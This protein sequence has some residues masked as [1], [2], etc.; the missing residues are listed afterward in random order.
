MKKITFMLVTL[1]FVF[2]SVYVYADTYTDGKLGYGQYGDV[3]VFY[4]ENGT[5]IKTNWAMNSAENGGPILDN[6]DGV[7][8]PMRTMCACQSY[9]YKEQSSGF[10]YI[11]NGLRT[12]IIPKTEKIAYVD[13]KEN[14][15]EYSIINN[16]IYFPYSYIDM[17]FDLETDWNN[18]EHCLT[19]TERESTPI[20]EEE[21]SIRKS[22]QTL[23]V[24]KTDNGNLTVSI[25]QQTVDFDDAQPFIDE[26]DRTQ[27]PVRAV[28][29]ALGCNVDWNNNTRTVSITD[30]SNTVKLEIGSDII[31]VGGADIKM[32]TNALIKEDR[33]YIPV[34]F[35]AEALGYTV[36]YTS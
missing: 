33:T 22:A 23:Y 26:N 18:T 21:F 14:K 20:S 27:M 34:R 16:D 3:F 11:S 4:I 2:N 36:E 10:F 29:E 32:D 1:L 8:M 7:L 15:F 5:N 31:N 13:G 24:A 35:I 6:E 12:I 9:E 30:E 28:A 19:L 17:L 25:D